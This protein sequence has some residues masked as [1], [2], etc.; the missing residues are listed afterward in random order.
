MIEDIRA[1]FGSDSLEE[2]VYV[3]MVGAPRSLNRRFLTP[4]RVSDLLLRR[5]GDLGVPQWRVEEALRRMLLAGFVEARRVPLGG[6]TRYAY[7]VKAEW[8]GEAEKAV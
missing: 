8:I 2:K 3:A 5:W 4:T 7:R 6:P 1:Y